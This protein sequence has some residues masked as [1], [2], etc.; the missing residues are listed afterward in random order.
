MTYLTVTID[1]ENGDI[2]A[3]TAPANCVSLQQPCF[4]DKLAFLTV[5][6]CYNRGRTEEGNK[7][8]ETGLL[9]IEN[10]VLAR[11]AKQESRKLSLNTDS[12]AVI[13]L[14]LPE[15]NTLQSHKLITLATYL[16]VTATNRQTVMQ[17]SLRN[18][19]CPT[20]KSNTCVRK[21]E[22]TG[23][24]SG[25]VTSSQHELLEARTQRVYV[26][27]SSDAIS[28]PVSLGCVHFK[29]IH[30]RK[31]N[32]CKSFFIPSAAK[33][34]KGQKLVIKQV[35]AEIELMKEYYGI[36]YFRQEFYFEYVNKLTDT[37]GRF[38]LRH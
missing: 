35:V 29:N 25:Q 24:S 3:A 8:G 19:L 9:T 11:A 38:T 5:P 6:N 16:V 21:I 34:D 18:E 33:N 10:C 2:T 1:D 28:F 23:Y 32:C 13:T 15:A 27:E 22:V 14:D 7:E 17:G 36:I 12:A 30:Q 26:T 37:S 4:L 31:M 20:Y